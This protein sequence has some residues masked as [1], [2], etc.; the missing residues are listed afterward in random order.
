MRS[1]IWGCYGAIGGL[2]L[3]PAIQAQ[4]SY[5]RPPV[6]DQIRAYKEL[7]RA[8]PAQELIELKKLNQ[9]LV[10]DIR[11]ASFNNFTGKAL[12][13][14][15]TKVCYLRKP[16]AE[17]LARVALSLQKMGL[18]LKIFDSYRPYGVT[19]A[20]WK[21]IG[22]ERYVAHPAKGSGH[23][24]GIAVD[25]TL[26]DLNTQQELN[27]GTGFDNFSDTAH[28]SF[29]GLS[30]SVLQNRRIL[31]EEMIRQGFQPLETEWW[32]YAFLSSTNFPVLNIPFK[33]LD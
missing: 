17:A 22:D 8:D 4:T 25:L 10:Y 15:K 18:G 1:W 3:S 5:T 13:P 23:N 27:M 20:F 19:E 9:G 21:L 28:H 26:I 6:I 30:L 31:R 2:F 32:H 16:A 12:Y 29:T 7:V 33:K 11:Y 24:R 14:A